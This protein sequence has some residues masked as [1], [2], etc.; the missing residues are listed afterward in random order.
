M[1]ASCNSW[2][3]RTTIVQTVSENEV[4]V[5]NADDLQS[6]WPVLPRAYGTALVVPRAP[7]RRPAV[8]SRAYR[9]P[10]PTWPPRPAGPFVP[11]LTSDRFS[12]AEA[13]LLAVRPT[14][15][16]AAT[17]PSL[18]PSPP[19][20]PLPPS[21]AHATTFAATAVTATAAS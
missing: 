14:G 2:Q 18:S 20:S 21:T 17:A 7:H 12:M 13:Q 1:V 9:R 15:A 4:E 6:H 5:V 8:S 19:P 3:P 10:A 11:P 16:A